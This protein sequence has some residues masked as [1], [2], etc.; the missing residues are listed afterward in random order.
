[1]MPLE[2][3]R[4]AR[5]EARVSPD[6]LAVVKR[7]AELQGR[8][9]SDFVVVAAREAAHAPSKNRGSFAFPSRTSS[10]LRKPFSTRRHLRLRCNAPSTAT[11]P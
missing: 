11:L 2:S 10:P 8:S 5:L 3:N 4:S 6:A 7:A 9:V 1:M